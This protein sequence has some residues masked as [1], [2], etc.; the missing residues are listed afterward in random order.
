MKKIV[1]I[2]LAA[3]FTPI[4]LFN[5]CQR[6]ISCEG[7]KAHNKP[8]IADAGRDTSIT[9]PVNSILLDGSNSTDPDGTITTYLWRKISG[10]A[11]FNLKNPNT[12]Q[13]TVDSLKKGVYQFELKVT[14]NSGLSDMDTL[15]ITVNEMAQSNRP[16][17]A[18]AGPDQ[19]ISL[20]VYSITLD[21][22]SSSDPDNNIVNYSWRKISGPVSFTIANDT[23]VKTQVTNLTEGIYEFELKVTDAG[24]LSDKD[25]VKV[26]M[27]PQANQQNLKDV[28]FYWP[29]PTGT[30]QFSTPTNTFTWME[31]DYH[32]GYL[33]LVTIKL[34]SLSDY[35]AGVWCQNCLADCSDPYYAAIFGDKNIVTFHLPPGIYNWSAETTLNVFPLGPSYNPSVTQQFFDYFATTHKTNG[36]ITVNPGDSCIIQKIVFQ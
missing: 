27:K 9:L 23:A 22:S 6:E 30:V 25:T 13:S 31:W 35:L 19:T 11:S 7:C 24:G 28:I 29:E 12:A 18:N 2:I 36:T 10:P 5:S 16:P 15:T 26:E 3:C 34:D 8:P 21:G 1:L 14:D 20:P 32:G 33:K 17:V 4:L